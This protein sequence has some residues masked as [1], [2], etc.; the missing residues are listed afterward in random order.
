MTTRAEEAGKASQPGG[1]VRARERGRNHVSDHDDGPTKLAPLLMRKKGH[2]SP[3][4]DVVADHPALAAGYT[5]ECQATDALA[6]RSTNPWQARTRP[7]SQ[8]YDRAW[9][10]E[11]R[12]KSARTER[13]RSASSTTA[14]AIH[15]VR[16]RAGSPVVTRRGPEQGGG[17]ARQV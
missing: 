17:S 10:E 11:D 2:R 1:E 3:N 4:G 12:L 7:I 9:A 15:R 14:I 6:G 13:R 8:L 5:R 16:V